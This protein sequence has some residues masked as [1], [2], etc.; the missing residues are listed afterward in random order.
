M[1]SSCAGV[2]ADDH[3]YQ[4]TSASPDPKLGKT[5]LSC[6]R[7]ILHRLKW[8]FLMLLQ[9][10]VLP[11]AT[12]LAWLQRICL[13]VPSTDPELPARCTGH[14]TRYLS[15]R[16]WVPPKIKAI[17]QNFPGCLEAFL[18]CG[19]RK[20]NHTKEKM[21]WKWMVLLN[22]TDQSPA[23]GETE[24]G[25]GFHAQHRLRVAAFVGREYWTNDI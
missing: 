25:T 20:R 21:S 2:T 19:T 18:S 13:Q 1:F 16:T 5:C 23:S 10:Y 4:M 22:A 3:F 12:F 8:S 24:C 15:S 14:S 6:T 7:H 9:D 11:K 17:T